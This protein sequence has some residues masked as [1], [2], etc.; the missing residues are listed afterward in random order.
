MIRLFLLAEKPSEREL[1]QVI[2]LT[3]PASPA[4]SCARFLAL[5]LCL[6]LC[7]GLSHAVT[8][9]GNHTLQPT[10]TAVR[11]TTA[12]AADVPTSPLARP[13]VGPWTGE[14]E[15][16]RKT[17]VRATNACSADVP[18]SPLEVRKT[19]VRATKARSAELAH[20]C[21]P[22]T[23]RWSQFYANQR[24]LLAS[25]CSSAVAHISSRSPVSGCPV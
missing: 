5:L 18:T 4:L 19:A 16:V 20:T 11:A 7:A 3:K 9:E 12:R 10:R 25:T 17:A 6:C 14:R 1:D 15:H 8:H 22:K 24:R 23:A 21:G 2:F 13:S